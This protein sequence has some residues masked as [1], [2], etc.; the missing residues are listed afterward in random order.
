LCE[1]RALE[2]IRIMVISTC[3]WRPNRSARSLFS[4]HLHPSCA[5]GFGQALIPDDLAHSTVA[6]G[7]RVG[8]RDSRSSAVAGATAGRRLKTSGQACRSQGQG[9]GPAAPSRKPPAD[10]HA[11]AASLQKI[12]T[13]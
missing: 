12:S 7:A 11:S 8:G 10:M 1:C 3:Y 5:A 13:E 2:V 4:P 9:S 6:V